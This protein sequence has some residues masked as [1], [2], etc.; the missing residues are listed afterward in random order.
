VNSVETLSRRRPAEPRLTHSGLEL[1]AQQLLFGVL[2]VALLVALTGYAIAAGYG[3]DFG[4]D[5]KPVWEAA[6]RILSGSSPYPPP[7]AWALRDEQQF[8]Y[9]PVAALLA[10]PFVALPFAVAASLYGLLLVGVGALTLRVLGV[11]DWRCYGVALLWP[12]VIQSITLGTVSLV[13]A[14]GLA[15][16]WRYRDKRWLAPIVIAALVAAKVFLW[17]LLFWLIATRRGLAGVRALALAIAAVLGS[18]ALIGF[19][20]L[21]SYPTLLSELARLLQSKSY[22]TM[23]LGQALGFSPGEARTA[24]FVAGG[25]ML[26]AI[27]LLGRSRGQDADLHAFVAAIAAA[28]LLSPIVWMHYFALLLIPI[29]IT[30]RRLTPLW[31]LPIVMWASLGQSHGELWRVALGFLVWSLGLGLCLRPRWALPSF[32]RAAG[33]PVAAEI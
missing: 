19:A 18:W 16:A 13:L 1:A 5:F 14:L 15:V 17:P 22:S 7:H 30:R 10:M 33:T 32:G 9:P 27:L 24:S 11:R 28:F 4:F 25:A 12:S 21:T 20:G 26:V 6:H 29:G 3:S 23:A 8:V 2:P 31:F